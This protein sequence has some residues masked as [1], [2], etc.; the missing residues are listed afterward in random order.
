MFATGDG[1][2]YFLSQTELQK[3]RAVAKTSHNIDWFNNQNGQENNL[4]F[5]ND[6]DTFKLDLSGTSL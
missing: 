4:Y 1:G 3:Q 2:K 5:N 6:V